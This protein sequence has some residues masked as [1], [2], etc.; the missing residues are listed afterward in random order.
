MDA[1]SRALARVRAGRDTLILVAISGGADSV[2][3][4]HALVDLRESFGY[5]LAA[6]H[7]NHRIRG[8]QSDRDE[9]FVRALCAR[10]GIDLVARRAAGLDATMP[11]LEEAAR[12]A[13][14][15]FLRRTAEALGATHVALGHHRD[16]QA[17]TI[18]LRM[19]RGTG[20]AG[21]GAMDEA[22]ADGILRPMLSLS[23][24]Q[25]RAYLHAIGA[26]FVEDSTNASVATMRN[27]IRHE[28]LPTLERD[29]A[30]GVGAR[31]AE[32]SGEMRTLDAYLAREALRELA[33]MRIVGG[34]L[35]LSRF[36]MLDPALRAPVL[37]AFVAERIGSLRRVG[38]AH[39]DAMVSLVQGGPPNGEISL[40]GRWRAVRAYSTLRLTRET[41]RTRPEFSV[42]LALEGATVVEAAGYAFDA[43]VMAA[44]DAKMPNNKSVALFDLRE[45]AATGLTVRNFL[46]GD[47]VR[48]IGM[49]GTRKV[50]DVLIDSKV[51]RERR[52]RIPIVA[53]EDDVVWIPGVV[54]SGHGLLTSASETVLR[55]SARE[56]SPG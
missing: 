32:L 55:I 35:E 48:P 21:L 28:L 30:R 10:L 43:V 25:I 23:R 53:A 38:R 19:L 45:I 9:E 27:R 51:A 18:L 20:I 26:S 47:R 2:A 42:P 3:M 24:E 36:A 1:I 12:E 15:G 54:R 37:R 6:A 16:D 33:A 49:N 7:L 50:K 46:P 14:H 11:N 41:A 22:R 39:L 8:A 5:R 56:V 40:P 4:L 29:Y 17:E 34:G 13:R 44:A 31:L 52:A